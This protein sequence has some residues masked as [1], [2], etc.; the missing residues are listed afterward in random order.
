MHLQPQQA[1]RPSRTSVLSIGSR[2]FS[3]ELP[4]L[5][6]LV[7]VEGCPP[8]LSLHFRCN[9]QLQSLLV[10]NR[11]LTACILGGLGPVRCNMGRCSKGA[12]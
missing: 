10:G 9:K 1:A 4:F 2:F 12:T 6:L 7:L 11:N 5:L 8:R 3:K